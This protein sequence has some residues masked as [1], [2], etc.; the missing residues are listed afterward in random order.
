MCA[1]AVMLLCVTGCL[2]RFGNLDLTHHIQK[3]VRAMTE[4]V[5]R[6]ATDDVRALTV[7]PIST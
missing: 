3:A 4:A 6:I 7:A 2:L 5:A 1:Y